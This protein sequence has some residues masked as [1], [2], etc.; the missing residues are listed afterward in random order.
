MVV[1]GVGEVGC[2]EQDEVMVSARWRVLVG[3]LANFAP[4]SNLGRQAGAGWRC[5]VVSSG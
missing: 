3:V 4:E 5:G 2:W 1:W